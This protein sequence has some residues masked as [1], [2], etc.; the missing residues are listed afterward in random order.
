MAETTTNTKVNVVTGALSK[1]QSA[2]QGNGKIYFST[3][4]QLYYDFNGQRIKV[5]GGNSTIFKGTCTTAAATAGKVVTCGIFKTTDLVQGALIA[6]TFT[7]TNSGAVGSLTMDVDSTGAKPIKKQSNTTVSNL[8]NAGELIAGQTYFF[9]YDGTN[10]VCMNLDYNTTYSPMSATEASTGTAT[11][12][13]IITAKV[14]ADEITRRINSSIS[15]LDSSVS[16]E[17]GKAIAGFEEVNGKITNV[18]RID[19]GIKVLNLTFAD[20]YEPSTGINYK[21]F[22]TSTPAYSILGITEAEYNNL[23]AGYYDAISWN[24]TF[25]R[26]SDT[27][28]TYTIVAYKDYS[29]HDT[30]NEK[31]VN[32]LVPIMQN[33]NPAWPASAYTGCKYYTINFANIGGVIGTDRY[34]FYPLVIDTENTASIWQITYG[35]ELWKEPGGM[36]ER[37]N[38]IQWWKTLTNSIDAGDP[39]VYENYKSAVVIY[40]NREYFVNNVKTSPANAVFTSID[41]RTGQ[42]YWIN[43]ARGP[44]DAETDSYRTAIWTNGSYSLLTGDTIGSYIPNNFSTISVKAKSASD[45]AIDVIPNSSNGTLTFI[46]S[47]NVK[48]TANATADTIT[49][50]A[51]NTT[52]AAGTGI[53]ITGTNNAINATTP[54]FSALDISSGGI[55]TKVLGDA[56]A[57]QQSHTSKLTLEAGSNVSL[58]AANT[59]NG[60]KVTI[61]AQM[62]N[63]VIGIGVSTIRAISESEYAALAG[64]RDPSTVYIVTPDTEV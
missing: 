64:S 30:G 39:S 7:Y 55:T 8:T 18:T 48:L 54:N 19:T 29:T 51:S 57:L 1:I 49:I 20:G 42:A 61:S 35:S 11:S 33:T 26:G 24:S 12:G 2:E 46:G 50:D 56:T 47:T 32:F 5:Q 53:S 23:Y 37:S 13:R 31:T 28:Q 59:A 36:A 40:E 14:L 44:W 6:V 52:Y 15:G 41:T 58:T 60:A 43:V 45:T 25:F 10:W 27:T 17:T 21:E 22:G 63:G 62:Q 38:F 3:E 34:Y 16:V 9:Q 4:G